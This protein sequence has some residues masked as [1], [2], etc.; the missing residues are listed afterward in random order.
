MQRMKKV[1]DG[2]FIQLLLQFYMNQ[3]LVSKL[4]SPSGSILCWTCTCWEKIMVDARSRAASVTIQRVMETE[5]GLGTVT[6]DIMLNTLL[7]HWTKY[8]GKPNIVRTDPE[9][10][11]RYQWFRRGLA[12]CI[13][14]DDIDLG[15]ASWKTEVLGKTADVIKQA[16]VRV[17]RRTPDSVKSS[18]CALLLTTTCIEIDD[19]LCGSCCWERHR[20]TSRFASILILLRAV[21][22][23]WARLQSDVSE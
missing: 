15:D 13:R 3:A 9:G 23:L 10:A 8:N 12:K 17:T 20:Q 21:S 14:L 5:H 18:M 4:I 11:F 6:G 16:A 1:R 22:K 2:G 19:S 7:N